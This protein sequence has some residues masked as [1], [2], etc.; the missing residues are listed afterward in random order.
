M[1]D[2]AYSQ[3]AQP[4]S[5]REVGRPAESTLDDSCSVLTEQY[6]L[7]KIQIAMQE[8][9]AIGL[10][11]RSAECYTDVLCDH[12]VT[13]INAYVLGKTGQTATASKTYYEA[14]LPRWIPRW[15]R[16][17]WTRRRTFALD[18]TPL[19]V[20]PEARWLPPDLGTP[21]FLIRTSRRE[22]SE[23]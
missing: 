9:M 19:L 23:A 6:V 5:L 15:L 17:R 14:K 12:L 7:E 18:A 3:P 13:R 22:T 4:G 21:R 10:F 16:N 11:G 2:D 20:L 8:R 1:N